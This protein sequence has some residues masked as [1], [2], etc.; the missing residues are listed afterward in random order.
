MRNSVKTLTIAMAAIGLATSAA[1]AETKYELKMTTTTP[2]GTV[3]WKMFAED[4]ENK[5]AIATDG[6]MKIKAY[7]SGS[8]AGLF[9]GHK[10]VADGRADLAH[11]YPAFEINQS[12]ASAF[13]SDIPGGMGPDA[14]IMWVLA[15]GG[16]ELW[17]GYRH[18]QGLH[19]MMCGAIGAE[20]FAHSHKK[21]QTLADLKGFKYRTAGAN[22]QVMRALGAAPTL[23]PG[24]EVFTLLERKGV[25]GAE[26]LD[27]YGNV[28]LGFAKIAKYVILPGIHA[29]GALYELLMKKSLWDSFPKDI[30]QK[31]EMVCDSVL[32]NSYATTL[33]NNV[34]AM[35]EIAA[36]S[37][38]EIVTLD[39]EVI[40]AIRKG[41]REWA[42]E[43]TESEA[44]KGNPW[45]GRLAE[46]YY[47]FQDSWK[48]NSAYQVLDAASK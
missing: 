20:I 29:P 2:E 45:M 35:K 5:I 44:K 21:I 18:S 23:V 38:N 9:E 16:K 15:G 11:Q 10:A 6:V 48:A 27:P 37:S 4:L 25:D 41:G 40:D 31:M 26:Y 7:G 42:A 46:S 1:T 8:L 39:Q 43:K 12:P 36:S 3:T 17:A 33:V 32:I 22:T 13:I 28:T 30:Q 47:A 24:P 19:G 34:K 14:K